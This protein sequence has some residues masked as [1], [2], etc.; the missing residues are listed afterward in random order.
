MTKN[1]REYWLKRG[2]EKLRA[3]FPKELPNDLQVSVGFPKGGRGK[4][5]GQCWYPTVSDCGE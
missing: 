5:I 4:A 1:T 2:V 3:L